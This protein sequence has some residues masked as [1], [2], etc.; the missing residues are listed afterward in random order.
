MEDMCKSL[1]MYTSFL[2]YISGIKLFS[3]CPLTMTTSCIACM[4]NNTSMNILC[5]VVVPI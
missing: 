1:Y 2:D 5:T 3:V 4:P